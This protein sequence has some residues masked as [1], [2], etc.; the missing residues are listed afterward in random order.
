MKKGDIMQLKFKKLHPDA[1]L[2]TRATPGSAAVDLYSVED[3][4]LA[5]DAFYMVNTGWSVEIPPGHFG[6]IAPRSG[7]ATKEGL[8]LR[9]SNYLDSDY[10]GPIMICCYALG[11]DKLEIKRGERIAQMAIIPVLISDII[12]CQELTETQRGIGGFGSTGNK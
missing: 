12:E 1:I 2:P 9:S 11:V 4:V 5:R 7:K 3:V 6:L 8:I 10:R